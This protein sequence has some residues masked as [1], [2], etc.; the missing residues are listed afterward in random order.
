MKPRDFTRF[1]PLDKTKDYYLTGLA[2]DKEEK[3]LYKDLTKKS[4]EEFCENLV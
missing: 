3:W 2:Q 4:E 1:T